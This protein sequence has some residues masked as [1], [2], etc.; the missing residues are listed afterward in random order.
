MRVPLCFPGADPRSGC[1]PRC[2]KDSVTPGTQPSTQGHFKGPGA[3][4][5]SVGKRLRAG[6]RGAGSSAEMLLGRGCCRGTA[7]QRAQDGR[8]GFGFAS[9]LF[10][11]GIARLLPLPLGMAV[12]GWRWAK[13][14]GW[15]REGARR[16]AGIRPAALSEIAWVNKHESRWETQG[17]GRGQHSLSLP[18]ESCGGRKRE[19][20]GPGAAYP[21]EHL[22][23]WSG[24]RAGAVPS[25][26]RA[27][28]RPP[29]RHWGGWWGRDGAGQ[30]VLFLGLWVVAKLQ[31]CPLALCPEL[32]RQRCC[33]G[34]S[35]PWQVPVLVM[36]CCWFRLAAG[37]ED[38]GSTGISS[39]AKARGV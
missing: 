23:G 14:E 25:S 33:S 20:G 12:R 11:P 28:A 17:L 36:G 27:T 18:C 24:V 22:A 3:A 21:E 2:G 6:P 16:P 38:T 31:C 29:P 10:I 26:P 1:F 37:V 13:G 4:A 35:L 7:P 32:F 19:R 34:W 8:Q 5:C 9:A 15:G 39:S 30:A